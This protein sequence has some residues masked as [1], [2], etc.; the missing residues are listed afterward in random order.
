MA[1]FTDDSQD[2]SFE[3][4]LKAL[5]YEELLDFWEE[6]QFLLRLSDDEDI[7]E[8]LPGPEYEQ[9]ILQELQIR[10]CR[11]TLE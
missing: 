1:R 5:G 4:Q 3:D 6:T 8:A 7:R 2:F 10:S 9:L 11:R